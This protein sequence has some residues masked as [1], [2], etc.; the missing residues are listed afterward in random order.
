MQ[1]NEESKGLKVMFVDKQSVIE[2]VVKANPSKVVD[3]RILKYGHDD[4]T[5]GPEMFGK[6]DDEIFKV[7]FKNSLFKGN[8]HYIEFNKCNFIECDLEG[9]DAYFLILLKC[10]FYKCNF[11]NC[12]FS[13]MEFAWDRV[14]FIDCQFRNVE[15]HEAGLYNVFFEKCYLQNFRVVDVNP[16]INVNM[17]FCTLDRTSF[18]YISNDT[19]LDCDYDENEDIFDLCLFECNIMDTSFNTV[20]LKNSSIHNSVLRKCNFMDCALGEGTFLL[21]RDLENESYA[22]MDFQTIIKSDSIDQAILLAYFNIVKGID[23][24][25]IVTTMTTKTPFYTVFIS[26]SLKDKTFAN[27]LNDVLRKFGVNTFLW[28]KDAPNGELLEEVMYSGVR[29][30]DKLL[31]IASSSSIRSKACQFELSEGRR[32]QEENWETIF[33]PIFI[34][35]YLFEVHRRDIRPS[36]KVE[37]YWENILELRKV[38]AADFT[39]F[40]GQEVDGPDFEIA[41]GKLVESLKIRQV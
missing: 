30:H 28:E 7:T 3:N 41:V 24:K 20:D 37:E 17:S 10:K 5:F 39:K 23:I 4:E 33:C 35:R 38:N 15:W 22:S 2:Y 21:D 18:E 11:K 19:T 32:K 8:F 40:N 6:K 12:K 31:F 14:E 34:D 13:H 29:K 26:Y 1:D 36:E 16:A 27:R 25:K 9:M